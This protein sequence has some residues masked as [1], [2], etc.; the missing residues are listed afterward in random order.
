MNTKKEL[1][2]E[3]V[4]LTTKII[5][6]YPELTKYLDELTISIPDTGQLSENDLA[7]YRNTLKSMIDKYKKE[8][9]TI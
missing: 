4:N 6:Q 7:E 9:S 3:I 2:K 5:D 1:N 8:S